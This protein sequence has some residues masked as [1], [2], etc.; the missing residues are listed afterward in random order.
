MEY[1]V[2]RG[3]IKLPSKLP[4]GAKRT[5][6]PRPKFVMQDQIIPEGTISEDEIE[7]LLAD[8]RIVPLRQGSAKAQQNAAARRQKGGKWAVDPATLKGKDS[9]E[10]GM[11]ILGID[12]DFDLSKTKTEK[13]MVAQLTMDWDPTFQDPIARGFDTNTPGLT[14]EGVKSGEVGHLSEKAQSNLDRAK[15]KAERM[16]SR[17]N[18]G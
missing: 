12:P 3:S 7:A 8:G 13:E 11:L 4:E 10:L 16:R 5:A 18:N 9:E 1:V 15:A 14:S 17:D 6:V 2:A